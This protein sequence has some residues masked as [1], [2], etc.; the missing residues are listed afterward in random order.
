M[1]SLSERIA[2]Y[3]K[4]A[5]LTQEVLAEKCSV[6]AQA[7]SKWENGLSAP[8]ISLLPTLAKL[9]NISCD[10]LL[11]VRKKEVA[12]VAPEL[13]DLT[14]MMFKLKVLSKKGDI[15]NV[16]LP[17]SI[18]EVFLKSGSIRGVNETANALLEKI[19]L[20]QVVSLVQLGAVGKLIEIKSAEGDVVEG[21]VE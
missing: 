16:N 21:W 5:N 20:A 15:V 17:L 19:D 14:K 10:E 9:F 6:S 7:V 1:N 11:G 4:K 12:A 2:Y 3:R 13:V 8:D 18:A